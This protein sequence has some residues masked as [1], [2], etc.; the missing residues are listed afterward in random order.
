MARSGSTKTCC[1]C[2]ISPKMH[3]PAVGHGLHPAMGNHHPAP[4][5]GCLSCT[6][7]WD[8]IILLPAVGSHPAPCSGCSSCTLLQDAMGC[9]GML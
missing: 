5:N 7:Q 8:H 4:W 6:L 9:C 1:W 2:Q 3:H